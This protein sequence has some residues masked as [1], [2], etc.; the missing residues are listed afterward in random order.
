[1]F[2]DE[3]A[4]DAIRLVVSR[5]TGEHLVDR[6]WLPSGSDGDEFRELSGEMR[7]AVGGQ[8]FEV[9]VRGSTMPAGEEF[10]LLEKET[11]IKEVRSWLYVGI[12]SR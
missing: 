3:S 12:R 2:R 1:L 10:P 11:R 8:E 5:T 9:F 7:V 4:L 6:R